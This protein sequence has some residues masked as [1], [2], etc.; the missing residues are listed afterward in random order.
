VAWRGLQRWTDGA[1]GV[2]S[3]PSCV[4][5]PPRGAECKVGALRVRRVESKNDELERVRCA[6]RRKLFTVSVF[7]LQVTLPT[8]VHARLLRS[9]TLVP[10]A[11]ACP[12]RRTKSIRA[13]ARQETR[14]SSPV[15]IRSPC[16]CCSHP[17]HMIAPG[18][19]TRLFIRWQRLM[20]LGQPAVLVGHT[21]SSTASS[22]ACPPRQADVTFTRLIST[23]SQ[24]R[25]CT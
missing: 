20:C 2:I 24:R 13:P 17:A 9:C 21:C 12:S 22:R 8:L 3:V 15:Q 11:C 5:D 19:M 25:H 7:T 23:N 1:V 4:N 14:C 6:A 18:M 10:C 16:V